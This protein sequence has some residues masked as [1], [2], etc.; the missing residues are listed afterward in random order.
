MRGRLRWLTPLTKF[1]EISSNFENIK[2]I[3]QTKNGG[4]LSQISYTLVSDALCTSSNLDE[5]RA[6][7]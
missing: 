7:V 1:S 5:M 6:N 2:Q 4:S 3:S